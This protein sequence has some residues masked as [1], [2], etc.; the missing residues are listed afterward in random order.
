MSNR[1]WFG[2]CLE[3]LRNDIPDGMAD[4][5]YLD[6]PFNS[7]K[8]YDAFTGGERWV[9]FNDVWKWEDAAGDFDDLTSDYELATVMAGLRTILG[10]GSM[11]AYLSYMANRLRACRHILNDNGS[12][13]LHCYPTMAHCLKLIM[14][15]IFGSK[16]LRNEIVWNYQ[17]GGIS[18]K[19]FSPKYDTILWYS[20]SEHYQFHTESLQVDRSVKSQVR[21]KHAGARVLTLSKT[22]TDVWTDI[23]ALN[24][25]SKERLGYPTQKPV[26]LLER[27][28]S[29]SSSRG[30]LV[31][32]PFCGSGT[33]LYAAKKLRRDWLGVDIS[34]RACDVVRKRMG[35][36]T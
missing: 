36:L 12:I 33:T 27:I 23:P 8:V 26:A 13:Y 5:I 25:T 16:N 11:L 10:E 34:A 20:K 35:V 22:A 2:D 17:T 3:V 21:M 9:A 31:L 28:I 7:K 19:R 15:A 6:P 14:S 1:L 30:D 32:D 29:A 24:P 4:L 18:K